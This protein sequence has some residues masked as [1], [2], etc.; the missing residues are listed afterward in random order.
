M[1]NSLT[2]LFLNGNYSSLLWR[3]LLLQLRGEEAGYLPD[4]DCAEVIAVLYW[5]A[6]EQDWWG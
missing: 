6:G 3:I 1:C 4:S 5:K 2:L